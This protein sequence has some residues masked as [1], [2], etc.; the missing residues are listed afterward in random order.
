MSAGGVRDVSTN[1]ALVQE[2]V[3]QF[4]RATGHPV[5]SA[6]G[7]VVAEVFSS[8]EHFTAQGLHERMRGHGSKVSL[9][10][11]YRTLRLMVESGYLRQLELGEAEN[12]Y[13]PNHSTRPGHHHIRCK[14]CGGLIEFEDPCLDLRERALA[15]NMGF[16]ADTLVF[17]LEAHCEELRRSGKCTRHDPAPGAAGN[18]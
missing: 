7:E 5:T 6:R 9:M 16:R 1:R 4:L 11:V 18:G 17:R 15:E 12:H 13:D 8:S 2:R 14:D 3:R 10:T